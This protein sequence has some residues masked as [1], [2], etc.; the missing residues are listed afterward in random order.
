VKLN[1]LIPDELLDEMIAK[2]YIKV[3]DHPT[4]GFQIFNYTEQAQF[5]RMWNPATMNCRGL[6]VDSDQNIIARPW[7]K[8]FNDQEYPYTQARLQQGPVEVTDKMDGSLGIMYDRGDRFGHCIATRGSFTSDQA[9][10]ANLILL[11]KYSDYRPPAGWTLLFEIV[12]PENRIVVDYGDTDD[13]VL[14]GAVQTDTGMTVGPQALPNW[15]GPRAWVFPFKDYGEA[16]MAPPRPGKE[17]YVLRWPHTDFQIKLKQEDYVRLHR[18]VTGLNE[19]AVWERL[20]DPEAKPDGTYQ[21][22]YDGIPDEL[23]AWVHSVAQPL[24]AQFVDMRARAKEA[25]IGIGAIL[26][27]RGWSG[28]SKH[29]RKEFAVLVKETVAEPWLRTCLFLLA[30]GKSLDGFI[31]KQLRPAGE[32]KRARPGPEDVA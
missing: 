9:R 10:H 12:Y 4:L 11:E 23:H 17:G 19:R 6:I 5:Q 32:T 30:D 14:L 8:F 20:S 21:D 22:L 7:R 25:F 16:L 29:N 31:W 26:R 3:T 28:V 1:E 27:Y 18:I 24:K 15:P 2:G 13:L